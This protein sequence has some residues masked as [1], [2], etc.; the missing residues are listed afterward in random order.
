ML[1]IGIFCSVAL[2]LGLVWRHATKTA[3]WLRPTECAVKSKADVVVVAVVVAGIHRRADGR[4]RNSERVIH[5]G[6]RRGRNVL[7]FDHRSIQTCPPTFSK[8]VSHLG[9]RIASCFPRPRKWWTHFYRVDDLTG[10]FI[11]PSCT[12]TWLYWAEQ[13]PGFTLLWLWK[14]YRVFAHVSCA[15][16]GSIVW[17]RVL[18]SFPLFLRGFDRCDRVWHIVTRFY[19]NFADFTDFLGFSEFYGI[20]FVS[21]G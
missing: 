20:A 8:K 11:Q 21:F 10:F 15:L 12:P 13:F 6:R 1:F 5:H 9:R 16:L 17:Y 18:P 14:Y 7:C 3:D 19:W 4:H 2:A